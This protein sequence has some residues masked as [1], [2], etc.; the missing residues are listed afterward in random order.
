MG[1]N[2][3]G[4]TPDCRGKFDTVAGVYTDII[5]TDSSVL[6]TPLSLIDPTNLIFKTR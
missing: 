1:L 4:Q 3:N 5:Q 2:E 6:E